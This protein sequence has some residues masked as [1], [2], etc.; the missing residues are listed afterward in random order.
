[1]SKTIIALEIERDKNIQDLLDKV[2]GRVYSMDGIVDV[3]AMLISDSQED[4]L[5]DLT[6]QSQE[7]GLWL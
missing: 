1:M 2:A 4:A 6:K 3:R 7:M 5:R